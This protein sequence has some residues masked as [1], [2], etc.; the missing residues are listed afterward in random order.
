MPTPL[1]SALKKQKQEELCEFEARLFYTESSRTAR[2]TQ[3][4]PVAG[5]G[6]KQKRNIKISSF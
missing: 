3:R 2:T 4:N 1:I 6:E 5:D